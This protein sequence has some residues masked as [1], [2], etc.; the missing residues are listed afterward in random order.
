MSGHV[1]GMS[2]WSGNGIAIMPHRDCTLDLMEMN[3][4]SSPG[5]LLGVTAE[6]WES[7]SMVP[8]PCLGHSWHSAL[9]DLHY[10]GGSEGEGVGSL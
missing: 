6:V 7:H 4:L 10:S 3:T 2:Y 5:R 8:V 1:L 9:S